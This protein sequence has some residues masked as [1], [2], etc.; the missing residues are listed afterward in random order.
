MFDVLGSIEVGTVVAESATGTVAQLE[1]AALKMR[2]RW[3][4]SDQSHH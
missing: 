3:F 1:S 2:S 4:K